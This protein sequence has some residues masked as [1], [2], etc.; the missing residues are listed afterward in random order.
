MNETKIPRKIGLMMELVKFRLKLSE[1]IEK[2]KKATRSIQ[3]TK[4]NK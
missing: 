4:V 2:Y 3:D 1:L